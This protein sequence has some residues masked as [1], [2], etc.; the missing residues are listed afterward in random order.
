MLRERPIE[1]PRRGWENNIKLD[2]K[3]FVWKRV[4]W[5]DLA[6]HRDKRRDHVIAGMK[7]GSIK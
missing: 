1:I 7:L 3:K 4:D 2:I 6:H 5:T